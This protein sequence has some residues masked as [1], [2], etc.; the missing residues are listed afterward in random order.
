MKKMICALGAL[1]LLCGCSGKPTGPAE[2]QFFA[3]DTVMTVTVYDEDMEQAEAAA[4]AVQTEM[5]RL[6]KLWSRTDPH[7][8][9]SNINAHAGD[10]AAVEV[11]SDTG[12]LL[13]NANTAARESGGAFNPVM[14]PVMDAWG[15]T[16]EK[17]AVPSQA[18]LDALLA[19]TEDLPEVTLNQGQTTASVSLTKE[20]QSLDAGAI[21]KGVAAYK[22]MG[23]LSGYDVDFAWFALGGNITACGAKPDGSDFRVAVKDPRNTEEHLC[24]LSLEPYK[25]CSTSGGY[26]RYFEENGRRYHHIIDPADGY[27]ADSG[28]LSVTVVSEDAP[29][30]DAYSTACFV[31]GAEKALEFW[32]SNEGAARYLDLILVTEEGHVYVT[33]GLEE[34]FEF[35]GEEKGYTYEIVRR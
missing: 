17:H 20:G 2:V 18:E 22:A 8:D 26:E 11:S 15:F 24:I 33:E 1:L 28:L 6:D 30:A 27:P 34:G 12:L 9:I 23:V 10:G 14:A 3:M 21:A 7:S 19:L 35:K 29:W 32:R 13:T 16:R 25:S 4:R 5:N 31:M